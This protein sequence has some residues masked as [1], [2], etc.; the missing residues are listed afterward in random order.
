MNSG[1]K[2]FK[3]IK[4]IIRMICNAIIIIVALL[5]F[6]IYPKGLLGIIILILLG[7]QEKDEERED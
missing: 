1:D 4:N 3:K 7:W 6:L 2:N 5:V